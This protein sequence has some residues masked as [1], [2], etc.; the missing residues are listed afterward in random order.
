MIFKI[1]RSQNPAL[2][3]T[4][5]AATPASLGDRGGG[6]DFWLISEKEGTL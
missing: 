4:V 6:E 3:F 5:E 2:S 1:S